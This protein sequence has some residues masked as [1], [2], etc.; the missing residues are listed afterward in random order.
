M[1]VR[2][3]SGVIRDYHER[4]IILDVALFLNIRFVFNIFFMLV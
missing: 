2:V 4:I 1:I 3:M